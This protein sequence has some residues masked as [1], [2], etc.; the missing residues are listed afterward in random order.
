MASASSSSNSGLMSHAKRRS[1]INKLTVELT[2]TNE[3]ME[4]SKH[5]FL[6]QLQLVKDAERELN[7]AKKKF[8]DLE[9]N[10]NFLRGRYYEKVDI[11]KA[12]K[13]ELEKLMAMD[14]LKNNAILIKE[15]SKIQ[16]KNDKEK[17]RC[18]DLNKLK[19][20]PI[21]I[22]KIIYD[23]MPYDEKIKYLE[24]TYNPYSI[25]N[26]L[27]VSIK[28]N[29]IHIAIKNTRKFL[30]LT[31]EEKIKI[32]DKIHFAG[33]NTIN[34][35][36]ALFIYAAKD[37]DPK[38]LYILIRQMCILFKKNKKYKI[39]WIRFFEITRSQYN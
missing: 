37:K 20:L 13:I 11:I 10:K 33:C 25:F 30:A 22:C 21:E 31:H 35:E 39:N 26:K 17:G 3:Q 15:I 19:I 4:V 6:E 29:F 14:E 9:Y 32:C 18:F 34:D 23:Y 8:T 7:L 16:K 36:I 12:K 2:Q 1:E 38:D 5:K 27:G 24:S 28:R